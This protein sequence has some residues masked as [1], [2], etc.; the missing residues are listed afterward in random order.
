MQ[1]ARPL[2]WTKSPDNRAG[3]WDLALTFGISFFTR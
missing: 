1:F 3:R 2:A